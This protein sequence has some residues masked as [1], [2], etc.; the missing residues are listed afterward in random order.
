[1]KAPPSGFEKAVRL[2][3]LSIQELDSRIAAL[4]AK[5]KSLENRVHISTNNQG[6]GD[7]MEGS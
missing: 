1:M 6:G 4:E 5:V 7:T 3:A 2:I